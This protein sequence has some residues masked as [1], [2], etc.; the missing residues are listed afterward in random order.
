MKKLACVILSLVLIFSIALGEIPEVEIMQ[1]EFKDSA[2]L[3]FVRGMGMGWN[4]GNTFDANSNAWVKDEMDYE[5]A[6]QGD[7]TTEELIEA[8]KNAGFK[9]LRVPVSWHDHVDADF[10]ISEKWLDRVEEV[11]SW[12]YERD[13]YVIINIHHDCDPAYYYPSK[14]CLD[15]SKKYVEAIWTQ[16]SARFEKYGEKLIF[17]NLNE[18]RLKDT[19]YEWQCDAGIAEV[20]ESMACINVLNQLF[21]NTVRASGGN[22]ATRYLMVSGYDAAPDGALSGKFIVPQDTADNKIIISTH[23]YIPYNYA[24]QSP[25]EEGSTD[26]WSM[27]STASTAVI[28]NTMERLYQRYVRVGIP[29]VMGEFGS[30]AKGDNIDSRV[31]HAAYYSAAAAARGIPCVWWDNNAFTGSGELFGIINRKTCTLVYPELVEALVKYAVK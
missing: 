2:A 30:R 21:V 15:N 28:D 17:E 13:M 7:K 16:L 27:D 23:A 24:L 18:P 29:V 11:V 3:E 8:L 5:T 22:N 10:N 14:A 26:E 31:Q 25:D 12:A 9:T 6:W 19:Q 1:K 20:S 4:L